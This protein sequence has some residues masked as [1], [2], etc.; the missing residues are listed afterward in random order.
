MLTKRNVFEAVG[1]LDENLSVNFN[2][3][4]YCLRVQKEGYAVLVQLATSLRHYESVTRAPST[5][6]ANAIAFGREHGIFFE[7][8]Q[9]YVTLGEHFYSKN[10]RFMN[11]FRMLEA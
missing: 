2:D 1:G 3:I 4:D 7:R 10:F 8:W 5:D 9:S 11:A 6:K